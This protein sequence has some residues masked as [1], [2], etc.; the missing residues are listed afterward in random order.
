MRPTE[1]GTPFYKIRR[2]DAPIKSRGGRD[3]NLRG[4]GLIKPASPN[5]Q[6]QNQYTP[7]KSCSPLY[8]CRTK[9]FS[10]TLYN[11]VYLLKL[12]QRL[13]SVRLID[14]LLTLHLPTVY[15]R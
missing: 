9:I 6:T 14:M 4:A 3:H 2:N 15:G 10:A 13:V 12:Q 5:N 7:L 11:Y 1:V 8:P